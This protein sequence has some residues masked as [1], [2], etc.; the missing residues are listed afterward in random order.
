MEL[1]LVVI[2]FSSKK[3]EQRSTQMAE[4]F[5]SGNQDK[6]EDL[7]VFLGN[8]QLNLLNFIL[9]IVT[10][11]LALIWNLHS[12]KQKLLK[13]ELL[14]PITS[15]LMV[16]FSL[17]VFHQ[18]IQD[19]EIPVEDLKANGTKKSSQSANKTEDKDQ[20]EEAPKINKKLKESQET[21]EDKT[22]KE[23]PKTS[24][25]KSKKNSQ[26]V[27]EDEEEEDA[28]KEK[29]QKAK[30][31]VDK[32]EEEEE[33]GSS[34]SKEKAKS[35]EEKKAKPAKRKKEPEE[36]GEKSGKSHEENEEKEEK[37]SK[38][39]KEKEEK[40]EKKEK[41]PTTPYFV[42]CSEHREQARKDHPEMKGAEIASYL[43]SKW[44]AL[45]DEQKVNNAMMTLTLLKECIQR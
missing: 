19:E 40:V 1:F 10:L 44:K 7:N 24:K 27:E 28:S 23:E 34:K 26:K 9:Q 3:A 18:R 5:E 17:F 31:K 6:A 33:E 36:E 35:K 13:K 4:A 41:R 16:F 8:I 39:K 45:S 37:K 32:E 30:P 20:E 21:K 14:N 2:D 11:K 25:G 12:Q 29:N 22:K 43:A 42:Y 38:S 15:S